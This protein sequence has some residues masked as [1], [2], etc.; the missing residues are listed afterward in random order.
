MDPHGKTI[1]VVRTY[2]ENLENEQVKRALQ[3]VDLPYRHHAIPVSLSPLDN[4][5]NAVQHRLP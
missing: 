2:P 5:W 3:E 1:P 4:L